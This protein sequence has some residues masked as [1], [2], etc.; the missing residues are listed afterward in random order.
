MRVLCGDRPLL[1]TELQLHAIR[2]PR[3]AKQYLALHRKQMQ[4]LGQEIRSSLMEW[5]PSPEKRK[6]FVYTALVPLC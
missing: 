3:F 5:T 4:A 6:S 2:N 1:R